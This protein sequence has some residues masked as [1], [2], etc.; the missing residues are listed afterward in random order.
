MCGVFGS[1]GWSGEAVDELEGRLKV[2]SYLIDFL[3]CLWPSNQICYFVPESR[4]AVL[5]Y[6]TSSQQYWE[7][8][9]APIRKHDMEYMH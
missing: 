1:F 2:S 6:T 7:F 5:A 3:Q 8:K 9:Q 4:G